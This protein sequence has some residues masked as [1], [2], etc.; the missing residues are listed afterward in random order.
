VGC[1]VVIT[2]QVGIPLESL[3]LQIVTNFET[4]LIINRERE[5][6]LRE[7]VAKRSFLEKAF[8]ISA[9]ILTR[10]SDD[11]ILLEDWNFSVKTIYFEANLYSRK[12]ESKRLGSEFTFELEK[13]WEQEILRTRAD[14]V[15]N[16]DKI[17][18]LSIATSALIPNIDKFFS[19]IKIHS[20]KKKIK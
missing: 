14:A 16:L 20:S 8:D 7:I 3:A 12:R 17:T 2:G 4:A 5:E 18:E 9:L 1:V 10:K 19:T 13:N 15:C 6:P 11:I